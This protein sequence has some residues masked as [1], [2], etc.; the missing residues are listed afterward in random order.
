MI[1]D[2]ADSRPLL[3]VFPAGAMFSPMTSV[4]WKNI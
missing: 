4:I 1:E 3:R 2:V